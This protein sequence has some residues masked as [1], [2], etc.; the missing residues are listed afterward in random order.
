MPKLQKVTIDE[1]KENL[2]ER[3]QGDSIHIRVKASDIE[4]VV[5]EVRVTLK[6][7]KIKSFR[8]Y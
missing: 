2:V 8:F 6:G 3:K 5:K 7:K 4:S 1:V